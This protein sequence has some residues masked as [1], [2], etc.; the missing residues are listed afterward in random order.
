MAMSLFAGAGLYSFHWRGSE[1]RAQMVSR[2]R[3]AAMGTVVV[4]EQ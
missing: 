1:G 3:C 4:R 2:V